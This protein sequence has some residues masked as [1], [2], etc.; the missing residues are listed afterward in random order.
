M[1]GSPDTAEGRELAPPC[2][3]REQRVDDRAVLVPGRRMGHE[4]GRLVDDEDVRVLVDDLERD[5]LRLDDVVADRRDV[6][7]EPGAGRD[8]VP[9]AHDPAVR[10]ADG[11][12]R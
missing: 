2:V 8:R 5:G 11:R 10:G 1:P 9:G 3:H 7:L 12:P 4:A 6:E